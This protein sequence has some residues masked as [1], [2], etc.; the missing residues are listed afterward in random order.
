MAKLTSILKFNGSID[1]M[2]AY[3]LP[4]VEA[5]VVRATRGPSKAD[6][7]NKPQYLNTRR[8]LSETGGRGKAVS[9]LMKAFQPLKPLADFDTAGG[10]NRLL[11]AV[12]KG[13]TESAYGQ[14]GVLLSR[15]PHLLEGFHLTKALPF[16]SVVRGELCTRLERSTLTA[17]VALPGLLPRLTFFPP[18][19]YAYC[20][21][22]ATLGVAPDLLFGEQTYTTDGDYTSCFA[23]AAQTDWFAPAKGHGPTTLS[24][25]LP[26]TPPTEAFALVW[27]IG[28]QFGAPGLTGGVEPVR[29]RVGSAKILAA[30]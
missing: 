24:L 9:G 7:E 13:D 23:L 8:N 6:I 15:F 28:V 29:K 4:G 11:R 18:S 3:Q 21:L 10:L 20:R 30:G 2:T 16:D 5:Q 1:G 14:R 12:Q 25:Q 17:T 22:V 19:D 26:Y 27:S